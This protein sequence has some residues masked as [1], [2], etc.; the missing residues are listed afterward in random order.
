MN[1]TVQLLVV[2]D[3]PEYLNSLTL[4]MR[5]QYSIEPVDSARGAE[6]AFKRNPPDAALV[7]VRLDEMVDGDRSGLDLVKWLKT[8]M[9]NLPVIVMSALDDPSLPDDSLEAGADAFLKKP[10]NLAELRRLL[11]SLISNYK[12]KNSQEKAKE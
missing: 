3:I 10:V 5:G 9:P 8:Q 2:D 6:A 4:V 11:D 7:D 1:K 12:K